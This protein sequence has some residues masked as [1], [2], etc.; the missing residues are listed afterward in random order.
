MSISTNKA[1]VGIKSI[2]TSDREFMEVRLQTLRTE[3]SSD[4]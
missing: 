3:L 2:M 1:F 4:I